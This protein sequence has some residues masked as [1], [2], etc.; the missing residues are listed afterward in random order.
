L[1]K[2][3]EL[4]EYVDRKTMVDLIYEMVPSIINKKGKDSSYLSE[5]FEESD[6]IKRIMIRENKAI[7]YKQ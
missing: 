4:D 6:S 2:C 5:S 1:N 7:S 3:V